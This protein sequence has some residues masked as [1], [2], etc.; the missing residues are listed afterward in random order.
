MEIS[1]TKEAHVAAPRKGCY[2][3]LTNY[4]A[5]PQWWPGCKSASLV[6]G[7]SASEQD[8]AL[9]FDTNSPV[10]EVECVIRFRVEPP[11]RV[12][13]ER[14]SGRLSRLNGDGWLLTD[15]GDGTTDIRYSVSAALDT[16]LPGLVERPFKSKAKYFFV[17]A[18][19]EALKQRAEAGSGG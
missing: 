12:R 5:F 8:V 3:I 6:D 18:P 11:E 1:G 9:V 17:E 10:G 4:E 16:G 14:L 2:D 15:R 19:V 7:G 13:P